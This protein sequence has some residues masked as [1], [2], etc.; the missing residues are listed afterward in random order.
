MR[1]RSAGDAA[2]NVIAGRDSEVESNAHGRAARTSYPG[3]A[4][5]R[6]SA[7]SAYRAGWRAAEIR[8]VTRYLVAAR[9]RH[10]RRR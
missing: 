6:L 2:A 10:G 4:G 7:L 1:L 3:G 9:C 5:W 8:R